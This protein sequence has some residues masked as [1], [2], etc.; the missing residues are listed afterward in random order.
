MSGIVVLRMLC[1]QSEHQEVFLNLSKQAIEG[2][3]DVLTTE[4]ESPVSLDMGRK[5]KGKVSSSRS[6]NKM[7]TASDPRRRRESGDVGLEKV[8]KEMQNLSDYHHI[9]LNVAAGVNA[10]KGGQK[11]HY[12]CA[13]VDKEEFKDLVQNSR[14]LADGLDSMH[15][16]VSRLSNCASQFL[17]WNRSSKRNSVENIIKKKKELAG[18]YNGMYD[19]NV[20]WKQYRRVECELDDLLKE[21]EVF[22][23]QSGYGKVL[24]SISFLDF[25]L[26]CK[27]IVTILEFMLLCVVWWKTW[28]RRN[29]TVHGDVLFL[30]EKVFG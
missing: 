26:A 8:V 19:G 29:Q 30:E 21:E 7:D 10:T 24:G 18:L 28:H 11:F 9:V 14:N 5:L 22:W 1:A 25:G 12:E 17:R 6:G 27:N 16:V 20:D 13:W 15:L 23:R 3:H 2:L 4:I